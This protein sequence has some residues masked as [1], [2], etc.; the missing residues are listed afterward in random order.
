M[1]DTKATAG[2]PA[3][4]WVAVTRIDGRR[5]IEMRWSVQRAE[6]TTREATTAEAGVGHA[7]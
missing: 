4:G 7:A 6:A 1:A 5:C 2:A 3:A